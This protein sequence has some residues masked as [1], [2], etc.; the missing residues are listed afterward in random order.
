VASS[1][2]GPAQGALRCTRKVRNQ[3]NLLVLK[4]RRISIRKNEKI[5]G[6]DWERKD[7]T[8]AREVR[9]KLMFKPGGNK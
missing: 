9:V 7:Q 3:W 2:Q 8:F 4:K 6:G 5:T 1:E